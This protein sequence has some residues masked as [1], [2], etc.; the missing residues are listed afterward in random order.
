MNRAVVPQANRASQH[1]R[2]IMSHFV[3]ARE[4]FRY[5]SVVYVVVCRGP[6]CRARGALP[7]RKRLVKLLRQEPAVDLIGY[8]CFG[9]CEYGPNVAFFPPGVWYCGLSAPNDADRVVRHAT[10]AQLLDQPPLRLPPEEE[11]YHLRNIEELVR[12]LE[13]DRARHQQRRRWWWPF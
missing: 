4:A 3:I 5:A 6:N 9:Q 8:S 13:R 10:G 11:P 7:L 12:T 1:V 2:P